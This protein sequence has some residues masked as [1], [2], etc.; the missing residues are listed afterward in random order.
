MKKIIICAVL[1]ATITTVGCN[2]E[3]PDALC[4]C[5]KVEINKKEYIAMCIIPDIVSE[6]SVNKLRM[7]NHTK[8]EMVYGNPFSMEYF[9]GNQW[10]KIELD[11]NFTLPAYI[12]HTGKAV[13]WEMNLYSLAEKYNDAKKGKYRYIKEL[14]KYKLYAGFEVK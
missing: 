9:N 6:T 10:E 7:E 5:G 14:G 4:P 12:L 11:F 8:K 1:F 3:K 2:K 13:E